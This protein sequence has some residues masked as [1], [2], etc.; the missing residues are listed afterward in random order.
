MWPSLGACGRVEIREPV[1]GTWHPPQRVRTRRCVTVRWGSLPIGGLQ[2][3]GGA[4]ARRYVVPGRVAAW[5]GG[6][7]GGAVL[8]SGLR[9]RRGAGLRWWL[10]PAGGG[11]RR[12]GVASRGTRVHCRGY[13]SPASIR[14]S[15]PG[16]E[17]VSVSRPAEGVCRSVG[18][19]PAEARELP[20]VCDRPVRRVCGLVGVRAPS[21]VR[22]S[23]PGCGR[24]AE[25]GGWVL[26][27]A[28]GGGGGQ[29][30]AMRKT[31]WREA[32]A[33]SSSSVEVAVISPKY[34]LTSQ[35]QRSR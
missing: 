29:D 32:A 2:P 18:R 23:S 15:P 11:V 10:G 27:A 6:Q 4:G 22:G 12:S 19:S 21:S 24:S 25:R 7:G 30:S 34:A 35:P 5:P 16:Q 17:P 28:V 9:C 13:V 31:G 33:R 8:A 20:A 26:G 3:H 1:A 14:G